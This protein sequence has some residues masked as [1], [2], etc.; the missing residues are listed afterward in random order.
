MIFIQ[1]LLL[2]TNTEAVNIRAT[3]EPERVVY[4]TSGTAY[5]E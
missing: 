1:E 4:R 3:K 5:I 2:Q